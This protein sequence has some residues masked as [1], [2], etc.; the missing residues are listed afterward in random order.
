[1]GENKALMLYDGTPLIEHMG[2]LLRQA[3]CRDVYISGD[4]PGY[5]G[6]PDAVRHDGPAHAMVDFLRRFENRHDRLMFVPVDMPLIQVKCLQHLMNQNGSSGFAGFPLPAC[7]ETGDFTR[8]ETVRALLSCVGVRAIDLPPEWESAMA[9]I[10]TK[11]D[12]EEI[13]S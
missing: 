1:M 8:S 12:W 13:T 10:N 5:D 7:L 6:I 2:G 11:K 3:G 4:V 9:N